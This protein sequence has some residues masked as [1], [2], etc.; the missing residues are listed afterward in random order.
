MRNTL[1]QTPVKTTHAEMRTCNLGLRLEL[2][3]G[4]A[5]LTIRTTHASV[6]S[7]AISAHTT[8]AMAS[9]AGSTTWTRDYQRGRDERRWGI[10]SNRQDVCQCRSS[11]H[12]NNLLRHHRVVLHFLNLF[13]RRV[14]AY[15]HLVVTHCRTRTAGRPHLRHVRPSPNMT[16]L[17]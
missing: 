11:V 8:T 6:P 4:R 14:D 17:A 2:R 7:I 5:T 1:S 9:R 16:C 3:L 15:H 13:H 10:H 12:R